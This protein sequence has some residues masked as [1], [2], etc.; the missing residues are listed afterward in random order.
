MIDHTYQ[1]LAIKIWPGTGVEKRRGKKTQS[2]VESS[3][4]DCSILF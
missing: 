3:Q 1:I 2:S 4:V